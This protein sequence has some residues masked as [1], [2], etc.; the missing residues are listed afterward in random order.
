MFK[1][2]IA[3]ALLGLAA[4]AANAETASL[5]IVC[6]NLKPQG[7]VLIAIFNSEAGYDGDKAVR[8][9]AADVTGPQATVTVDGLVPGEYGL[10]MFHDV[11]G[12]G[13]MGMNPFGMPTEPF[14]FSNN[15][16]GTMGPA[17]WD[18]AHF[19]VV[20]PVTTQNIAF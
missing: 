9:A 2:L 3:A 16:K 17:G 15:A 11:D 18:A 6:D 20:A 7:K 4:T 19:T 8:Y 14:A 13:K 12:D 5:T 10:K 1:S